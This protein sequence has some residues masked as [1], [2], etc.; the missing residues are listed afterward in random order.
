MSRVFW[1]AEGE[2]RSAHVFVEN[3]VIVVFDPVF[4]INF[5]YAEY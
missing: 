3:G 1:L 2:L 4:I 5:I